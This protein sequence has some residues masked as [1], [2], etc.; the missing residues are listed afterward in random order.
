[1]GTVKR[2]QPRLGM[3]TQQQGGDIAKPHQHLRIGTNGVVVR[4]GQKPGVAPATV[5]REQSAISESANRS[6]TPAART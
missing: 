6:L 5:Y 3:N 2:D 4:V 1:M